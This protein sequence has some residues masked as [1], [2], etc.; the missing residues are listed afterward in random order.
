MSKGS[1]GF[2]LLKQFRGLFNFFE[3]F[4]WHK[5]LNL[6]MYCCDIVTSIGLN[7]PFID[8]NFP[9]LSLKLAFP[10]L[11]FTPPGLY[12]FIYITVVGGWV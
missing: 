9:A 11:Y 1:R 7:C 8:Y 2:F 10:S 4:V 12:I 3:D 5:M 6:R